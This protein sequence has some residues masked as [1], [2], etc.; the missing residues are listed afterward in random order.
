MAH[1]PAPLPESIRQRLGAHQPLVVMEAR[2]DTGDTVTVTLGTRD[3][4]GLFSALTGIL[5]ARGFNILEGAITTDDDGYVVDTFRGT[6]TGDPE[7]WGRELEEELCGVLAPLYLTPPDGEAVRQTV[8]EAVARAHHREDG[9]GEPLL[10]ID[11]SIDQDDSTTVIT[12]ASQDTPF[13]LYSLA[14]ALALQGISIR[15]VEIDTRE[16]HI[17]DVFRVTDTTGQR[18]TSSEDLN[19][20]QLAI[21]VTKQFSHALGGAAN[22][23]EAFTRFEDLVHHVSRDRA[24]DGIRNLLADPDA[25]S[26]LARLLGASDFLWEDFIRLQ[27]EALLPLLGDQ[28]SRRLVSTPMEELEAKLDGQL[29]GAAADPAAQKEILNRFKDY[30]SYLIDVDHILKRNTDF[31]FLSH[32]LTSLAEVVIRAAYRLAWQE[33]SRRYG[34]P[35]TAAGLPA[36]YAIFGL[37]KLG[38][39][40]L[41]YASDIELVTVYSDHGSTDGRD[42]TSISN[43]EFFER[44]VQGV[45]DTIT[46]RREGI[47]QIDLRLRPYGDDGPRAVHIES[48][49][50]YYGPGGD[51]HSAER[52]ALI[53]LRPI[54]GDA[55]LQRRV[56]SI[57]DQLLYEAQTVEIGEIRDLRRRQALEK[58]PGKGGGL[59]AKLSPGALVDLE[60]NVQILQVTHGSRNPRLRNPGIH[61]TLMEL[62][63]EGTIDPQEAA[64][65]I[66]A[67]RFLRN[68][69]NGLRMLRGNAQDLFLPD[70]HTAEFLHLA[71]RMGYEDDGDLSARDQ[72]RVDFEVET[73]AVRGFVERHLGLDALPERRGGNPADLVLADTLSEEV[74][75]EVLREAGFRNPGRGMVNLRRMASRG[76]QETFARLVVL[77][78]DYLRRSGD[79]DMALNN[80]ERFTEQVTDRRKFFNQLLAQPRRMDIM[81]RIFAGSRFLAETLIRDPVFLEWISDPAVISRP[82]DQNEMY[83]ELE[84]AMDQEPDRLE[85]LNVMRRFRRRE[86]LRIGTRDICLGEDFR[87]VVREISALARTVVSRAYDHARQELP[88]DT[89]E[90]LPPLCILAFGKLGGDELNYS[91]DIDLLAVY[92]VPQDARGA[93]AGTSDRD[94]EQLLARLFRQVVRDLSDHTRDGQAYR[95]DLRLRPWGNAGRLVY[96]RETLLRY[97]REEA[98]LWELQAAIKLAPIAGDREVGATVMRQLQRIV[99]TRLESAGRDRITATVRHLRQRAVEQYHQ[100]SAG[101]DVK[102]G[103]GGIRDIEFLVQALQ[104]LH[105]ALYPHVMTG[106]TLL[107][108]RHLEEAGILDGP[109]VAQLR[110]DYQFLR[111]IEHFL[112]VYDDQQLHA[113]PTERDAQSKLARLLLGPEGDAAALL[114]RL[115]TTLT[116]VRQE[117]DRRVRPA[118]AD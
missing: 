95:V 23:K 87:E 73:A 12:V 91:S 60:Y 13:F 76:E 103:E 106:N 81:L 24:G 77:A 37:G 40:A 74:S 112:Q 63:E 38:G 4:P 100:D 44:L 50:T 89:Q 98:E 65:M 49:I 54:G 93:G 94:T 39:S 110:D 36:E 118:A 66:R 102:N 6:I 109:T 97:Y 59:N 88:L 57:R 104:M 25:Q 26:D 92:D 3:S 108:L 83:T 35:R 61:A 72:L 86:I 29:Q 70:Y 56:V 99:A 19:R 55:D 75:T 90:T 80:W 1:Q 46:A 82:R 114:E 9:A 47:F 28:T 27:Y 64:A 15:S 115:D 21:L 11:I 69:I 5:G 42:T 18:I 105:Q 78:W 20:L 79:P 53:R 2:R 32:R 67:Y 101:A 33:L 22:P 43:R 7:L 62:S 34:T 10:P 31:F 96:S 117:Y 84:E 71:R 113:I 85:R 58:V 45:S 52:L 68:L 8:M 111:R 30:E 17:R 14:S 48:F 116:R 16:N 41:G 51:A 107:G